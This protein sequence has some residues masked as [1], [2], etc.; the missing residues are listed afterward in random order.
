MRC[1]E[2]RYGQRLTP[3]E[4]MDGVD[5]EVAARSSGKED[6]WAE[7]KPQSWR[8]PRKEDRTEMEK[9]AESL[10]CTLLNGSAWSTEK[11]YTRRYKGRCDIFFGIEHRLR[12]EEMEEKFNKEAKEGWRFVVDVARI[13]YERTSSED[14]MHISG[15]VCVADDSKL[16]A[17]VGV[18]EGR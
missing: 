11:K 3:L 6:R 14:R 18:E 4:A 12:M 15:G 9:E 7:E 8:L 2:Q 1:L 16:E 13:T 17:V 5:G 10:R